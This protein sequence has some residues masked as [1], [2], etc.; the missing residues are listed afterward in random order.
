MLQL[1]IKKERFVRRLATALI[2]LWVVTLATSSHSRELELVTLQYPPYE[3]EEAGQLKGIVVEIIREAFQRMDRPI[4]IKLMPWARA[5]QKIE[6]GHADAIFTAYKNPHRETFADFSREVLMMQE[7]SFFVRKES[8]IQF[9]GDWGLLQPHPI[10]GVRKV[11]YGSLFDAA[12]KDQR[13]QFSATASS[14][15]EAVKMLLKQRYEILVSNK[16][17]ALHIFK[18]NKQLDSIREL[19]PPIQSV[20]SYLA[21]SKKRNLAEIRDQFDVVL[22]AMKKEGIYNQIIKRFFE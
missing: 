21:F 12:V 3:Y 4:S 18:Q 17:G 2:G 10:G 11:S 6:R 9:D 15:E 8:P 5:I 13:V 20:P 16:Y 22:A 14:G 19:T 1:V 7:V